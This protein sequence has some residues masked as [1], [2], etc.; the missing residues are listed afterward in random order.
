[1]PGHP[2]PKNNPFRSRTQE[3]A[4][5]SLFFQFMRRR[6]FPRSEGPDDF[7]RLHPRI[8]HSLGVFGPHRAPQGGRRAKTDALVLSFLAYRGAW[9]AGRASD[10]GTTIVAFHD[11]VEVTLGPGEFVASIEGAVRAAIQRYSLPSPPPPLNRSRLYERFN[12]GAQR[13]L[14]QDPPLLRRVGYARPDK[15]GTTGTV[16]TFRETG[17]DVP[18]D[19]GERLRAPAA[20]ITAPA[21]L[22][23]FL[24]AEALPTLDTAGEALAAELDAAAAFTETRYK[25][26]KAAPPV[27]RPYWDAVHDLAA[28]GSG[29]PGHVG[30]GAF[31]RADAQKESA[32]RPYWCPY[33]V[34]DIDEGGPWMARYY[35]TRI[36]DDLLALGCPR[37][38][39]S[40]AFTGGRGYHVHVPSGVLG[41]PIFR[42]AQAGKAVLTSLAASVTTVPVDANLFSPASSVRAIGTVHEDT[43][44]SKVVVND[45]ELEALDPSQIEAVS[46]T[47][48]PVDLPHPRSFRPV[49]RLVDLLRKSAEDHR[50]VAR[51]LSRRPPKVSGGFPAS[52]QRAARGVGE[53]ERWG[54]SF[55]GRNTAAFNIAMYSLERMG[56]TPEGVWSFLLEVNERNDPPLPE[57]ELRDAFESA[58]R[59]AGA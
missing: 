9:T 12:K 5:Q 36:R 11:G 20:V 1:M 46:R 29:H 3:E 42:D 40:V 38:A 25:P 33:F 59:R 22:E 19:V 43:G 23:P 45:R 55:S 48:R 58:V 16:F 15:R 41:D 31:R 17:L 28:H 53:G 2:N 30:V 51:R 50:G 18:E 49:P 47:Y 32:D 10:D 57:R 54:D 34:F 21:A 8:L 13:L 44:R 14:A 6:A 37:N 52:L 26:H 39:I 35:A 24:R 27:V 56:W 4:S 7:V